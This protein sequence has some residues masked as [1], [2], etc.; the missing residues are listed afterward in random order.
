MKNEEVNT[1]NNI[2]YICFE[3]LNLHECLT[4]SCT[5]CYHLKCLE[6][7][8]THHGSIVCPVCNTNECIPDNVYYDISNNTTLPLSSSSPIV[9]NGIYQYNR[10]LKR[11]C[12]IM[13]IAS[14]F[15]VIFILLGIQ[16]NYK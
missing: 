11:C 12:L 4:L 10:A 16:K 6:T 5:K 3:L 15:I 13:P 1:D 9:T 14:C 8:W 7:W 2:C